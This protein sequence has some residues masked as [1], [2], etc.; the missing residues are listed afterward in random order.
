[1]RQEFTQEMKNLMETFQQNIHTVLP[2]EIVKFDADKQEAQVKPTAKFWKPDATK[3]DYPDIFEVPVFFMQG[4]DQTATIAYPV[5]PGDECLIFFTEQAL[6][7]WRTKSET[8]TDLRFD[9]SNAVAIIGFFAKPN[10]HVKRACDNES[11]IVQREE[12]FIEIYDGKIEALVKHEETGVNAYHLMVDG[13]TSEATLEI[14][15]LINDD[16]SLIFKTVGNDG[17]ARLDTKN[18]DVGMPTIDTEI[19]GKTNLI[20]HNMRNYETGITTITIVFDGQAGAI[21]MTTFDPN[22]GAVTGTFT[23]P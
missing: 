23:L 16:S 19:D 8:E 15:D 18:T 2:A 13:I 5:R 3:I 7:Q 17:I 1:M 11:I 9:I 10:P 14:T 4:I 20:T 21:N 22:S 6:D 12:T